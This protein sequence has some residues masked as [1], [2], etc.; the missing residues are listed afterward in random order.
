MEKRD[1]KRISQ[2]DVDELSSYRYQCGWKK[3][4]KKRRK[5]KKNSVAA[6]FFHT[7]YQIKPTIRIEDLAILVAAKHFKAYRMRKFHKKKKQ[8]LLLSIRCES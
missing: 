2:A 6:A 3:F 4:S 7:Y 5:K 1:K 8:F